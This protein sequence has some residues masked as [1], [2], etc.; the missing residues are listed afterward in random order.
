MRKA[1]IFNGPKGIGKDVSVS[2]FSDYL[3]GLAIL[4]S[5]AAFKDRLIQ[6][7]KAIYGV[8]DRSWAEMYT[9]EQ[10]E[11]PQLALGGLTPRQALI[12]ISE[13][14][15]KPN[16]GSGY[17]GEAAASTAKKYFDLGDEVVLFSDGGFYDETVPL[18]RICDELLVVRIH[19]AGEAALSDMGTFV[20]DSRKYLPDSDLY[21]SID[22]ELT[23]ENAFVDLVYQQTMCN[24]VSNWLFGIC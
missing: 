2:V 22:L 6:I 18:T 7:T 14:I 4:N 10:K 8:S 13:D 24:T 5:E 15:I 3:D 20:G 12:H 21:S 16:Y 19:P 17:F 1:I 11:K 23:K 9:R